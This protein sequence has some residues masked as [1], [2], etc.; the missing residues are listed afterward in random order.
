[1]TST[2]FGIWSGA[3]MKPRYCHAPPAGFGDTQS[4]SFEFGS[5]IDSLTI[6]GD[7][8]T[9]TF[10]NETFNAQDDLRI[11]TAKTA[12]AVPEPSGLLL[13]GVVLMAL[14]P[15]AKLSSRARSRIR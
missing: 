3:S 15:S 11:I 6:S 8:L 1:M 9:L 14:I 2:S 13:L 12:T 10:L 7:R 5:Q 4:K